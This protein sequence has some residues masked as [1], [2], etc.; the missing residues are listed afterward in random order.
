MKKNSDSPLAIEPSHPAPLNT[1]ARARVR[2]IG[3]EGIDGGR[4]LGFSVKLLGHDS[5]DITVEISDASFNG[6]SGIS[7]QNA[8]PMAYEKLV[9]LLATEDVL[10]SNKLYLTETDIAHYIA[11]HLSSQKRAASIMRD[12]RGRSDAAA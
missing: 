6:A 2:Y 12:R 11:R 7:I 1:P 5:I 4:R 3:F 8:A 9:Q 10:E